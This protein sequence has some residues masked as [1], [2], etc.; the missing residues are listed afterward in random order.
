[1]GH[2]NLIT[3]SLPQKIEELYGIEIEVIVCGGLHTLALTKF[4]RVYSWGRG[5]GG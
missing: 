5:E 2:G 4:G 1:M 3:C